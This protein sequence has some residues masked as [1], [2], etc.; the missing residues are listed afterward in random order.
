MTYHPLT[1]HFNRDAPCEGFIAW[2]C[3]SAE[4]P[5]EV[6]KQCLMFKTQT[7]QGMFN[8][9][10]PSNQ[11]TQSLNQ[12]SGRLHR[13]PSL[14]LPS[15]L[16]QP[17][18]CQVSFRKGRSFEANVRNSQR[19]KD[20]P[21]GRAAEVL[22]LHPTLKRNDLLFL[23]KKHVS[24]RPYRHWLFVLGCCVKVSFVRPVCSGF[25]VCPCSL[26]WRYLLRTAVHIELQGKVISLWVQTP[27]YQQ[28][29][30][31]SWF[32]ALFWPMKMPAGT[33]IKQCIWHMYC[34]KKWIVLLHIWHIIWKHEYLSCTC[35]KQTNVNIC[36]SCFFGIIAVISIVILQYVFLK[37]F[38][39]TWKNEIQNSKSINYII[40]IY[41]V[42]MLFKT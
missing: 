29:L 32:S 35:T 20:N 19:G 22:T 2:D 16:H 34:M 30:W 18:V 3:T 24:S 7:T 27:Y 8:H 40:I 15:N 4:S 28:S 9:F 37:P 1:P 21:W 14:W 10:N 5:R 36:L 31:L 42:Y 26:Q 41:N 33:V 23:E 25:L 12:A 6:C 11:Q 13:V 38:F 17:P 39:H